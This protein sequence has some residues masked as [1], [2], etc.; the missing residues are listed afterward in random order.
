MP[1][2]W[3]PYWRHLAT[4]VVPTIAYPNSDIFTYTPRETPKRVKFRSILK[5]IIAP[6]Y[7]EGEMNHR[8]I[9][10]CVFAEPGA[11]PGVFR[12]DLVMNAT[13]TTTP[14]A[15]DLIAAAKA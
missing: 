12:G 3:V 6:R 11:R 5:Q 1:S 7:C 9:F 13:A 10:A 14:R 8:E 2:T 15:E 4:S